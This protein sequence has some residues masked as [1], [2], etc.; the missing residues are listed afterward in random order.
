MLDN[1]EVRRDRAM[2]LGLIQ[3]QERWYY[4]VIKVTK[5]GDAIYLQSLRRTNV[6]DVGIIRERSQLIRSA[7]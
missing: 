1:G 7:K 6:S 2:H 4:A 5:M 3:D